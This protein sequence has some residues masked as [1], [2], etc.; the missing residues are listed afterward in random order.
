[1]ASALSLFPEA[2]LGSSLPVFDARACRPRHVTRSASPFHQG[3]KRTSSEERVNHARSAKRQ[4]RERTDNWELLQQW[5]RHPEQR[6]YESIRP[7]TLFGIP[8]AE[9]AQETRLAESTLR[10][11][12]D[13][14][15]AL[16]IA[17]LLRPTA[18]QREDHHRSLPVPMRQ[19]IV[20]LKAEYPDFSLREIADICYIQFDCRPSHNT[21][22]QVLADGPPPSR[23]T[24]KSPLYADIP[25]PAERRLAVIR[26]ASARLERDQH[27][28]VL[29]CGT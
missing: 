1:M 28:R 27:W 16:G 2:R 19:L 5:C 17:G 9:R 6:L 29:G 14:F 11:T 8:P 24:R 3:K 12:A 15:D 7:I 20:D 10:R 22:K 18:K 21:I 23:T 25:D 4:R 13:A 26:E